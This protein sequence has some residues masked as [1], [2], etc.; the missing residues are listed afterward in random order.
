MVLRILL[1]ILSSFGSNFG[2]TAG[3]A[4]PPA[5][6]RTT[7]IQVTLFGQTCLLSGPFDQGT[8]QSIHS[9]SPEKIPPSLSLEQA[10]AAALKLEAAKG[11]PAGLSKY[12][13]SL[14][15]RV[16]AQVGFLEALA[17]AR[18]SGK[19]AVLLQAV[20]PLLS[21]A[22]LEGFRTKLKRI[23]SATGGNSTRWNSA[24]I[25]QLS[26]AF[27]DAL[28]PHP[29]EEFHRAIQRLKVQYTCSY[30]ETDDSTEE[31]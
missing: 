24:A 3:A 11:L 5:G 25:E 28:D 16:G 26:E 14:S 23:D 31:R 2:M 27:Q 29:E 18:Q 6:P 20:T 15:R 17:H 13:E 10:K 4:T 9:I 8:L 30:G 22:K 21:E 19:S 12:R 1:I 7:D